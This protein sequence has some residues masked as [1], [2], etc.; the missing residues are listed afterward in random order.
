MRNHGSF[1]IACAVLSLVSSVVLMPPAF[2]V[3]T[4]F[5][6][7][8]DLPLVYLNVALKAGAVTDPKEASGLTNFMGEMLR[9]GTQTRTKEQIDLALDQMGAELEAETRAEAL[10]FRGAVLA[11]QLE[12][13]LALLEEILTQPSF[14]ES[15]IRKLKAEVT[16]GIL[17][18]LGVD[19]RLAGRRFAQF[20]FRGHPYGKPVLGSVQDIAKLSQGQIRDH[21]DRLVQD[22][23]LLVVG[24]GDASSGK[25]NDWA[26]R[27]AHAR[28]NREGASLEPVPAPSELPARELLI[29][30]KPNR[31]QT[32]IDF[33]QIGLRMTNSEFFPLFVGNHAF[34]GGS[35]SAR[36][37]VEIR[38][39]RG[40][41]YGAYSYFKHGLK[42]RSW[43]T[44]LFP[45]SKDA[46]A[47]LEYS[48]KMTETLKEKGLTQAEFDFARQSLV[49]SAGFMYNTPKK[50][51]EN[52]LLEKTLDLPDGFM[53][54][55]GPRIEGVSLGEVNQALSEFLRPDR[56]AISVVGTASELKAPLAKA[57]GISPDAVKVVPYTQDIE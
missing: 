43:Q 29:V 17:E 47:A 7:D 15:E 8:T 14:P 19:Q 4:R 44:H 45:A 52:T 31:T 16:S 3:E 10:I 50:R 9:R 1:L 56:L 30:D 41:S 13:F 35:F 24:A 40:W 23:L 42:P 46:A 25:I 5:E 49:N 2:A 11:A 51:V 34:G 57:A 27:L 18:E 12:P 33:G 26:D 37:M 48:L 55:Y 32:Q 28:P 6:R 39:N 22:R 54:S 36:L 38:V 53:K 20:L 21:Y